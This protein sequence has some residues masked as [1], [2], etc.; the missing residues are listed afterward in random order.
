MEVMAARVGGLFE[1]N[2]G[3]TVNSNV[4]PVAAPARDTGLPSTNLGPT[5]NWNWL[6][7]VEAGT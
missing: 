2:T 7:E 1:R 3:E 4:S 5:F 6:P